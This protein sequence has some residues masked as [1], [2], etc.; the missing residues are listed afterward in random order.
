MTRRDAE[1]DAEGVILRGWFYPAEGSTGTAPTIVLAHGFSAVKEM[2]LDKYAELFAA[3]GTEAFEMFPASMSR[4]RDDFGRVLVQW[5]AADDPDA[6]AAHLAQLGAD[7]R[8]FGV[9]PHHYDLTRTAL[10]N[11]WR[12][13]AGARWTVRHAPDAHRRLLLEAGFVDAEE[14]WRYLG[15]AMVMAL[16]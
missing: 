9:E 11:A 7:H 3:L 14:V 1:F 2:Y 8:K 6:M 12:R 5:V 16:R 15:S 10:I 4:Q 13:L